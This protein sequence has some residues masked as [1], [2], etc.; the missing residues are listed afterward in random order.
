[1]EYATLNNGVQ[2]PMLGYGVYQIDDLK[3]CEQCVSE[4]IESGYRSIDTAQAYQNEEAVG[5]A[6]SHSGIAREDIFLTTK[7]WISNAGYDKSK[8]SIEASLQK[9]KTDYIDLLLIHQPFND[10]YG[11]YHAMEEL[12]EQGVLRAIGVSNFYSDRFIDIAEFA[13]IVPAVNQ[14]EAHLF[15]QQSEAQ[16]IMNKYGTQMEAWSPLAEG[17]NNLFSHP[18]L[19]EIGESY[20]K[21]PAQVALRYLIQQGIVVIPKT[22][23]KERMIENI[24]IFDFKLSN[25]ELD[26]MKQLD[27]RKSLFM[28]HY[29]P[30]VVTH[31]TEIG[32]IETM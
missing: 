13:N 7:I 24:S 11:T 15:H 6:V 27:T 23:R 8:R 14:I 20:H 29:D 9:L 21:T 19:Q 2:M 1:M 4:A 16:T 22:I 31:L 17:K 26:R 18:L 5:N 12:Y 30:D 3:E 28:N 32:K 10:Y 25:E